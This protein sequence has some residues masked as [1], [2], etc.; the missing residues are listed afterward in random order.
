MALVPTIK[1]NGLG[2]TLGTHGRGDKLLPVP[3]MKLEVLFQNTQ[4]GKEMSLCS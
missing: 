3:V 1:I 2:I 4:A